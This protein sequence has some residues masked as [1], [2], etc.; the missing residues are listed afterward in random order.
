MMQS[1]S[2]SD[3][4]YSEEE[5]TKRMNAALRRALTTPPTPQTTVRRPRQKQPKPEAARPLA[6]P[7]TSAR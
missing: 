7:R 2:E 3:D 5:A 1:M 4:Q 6:K